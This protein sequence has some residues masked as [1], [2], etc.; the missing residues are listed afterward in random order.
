MDEAVRLQIKSD[1]ESELGHMVHDARTAHNRALAEARTDAERNAAD[2]DYKETMETVTMLAREMFQKRLHD[3]AQSQ[4]PPSRAIRTSPERFQHPSTAASTSQLTRYQLTD[5]GVQKSS[6]PETRG[7]P[8]RSPPA[9][10]SSPPT[11]KNNS[12][13]ED[14]VPGDADEKKL[15]EGPKEKQAVPN[16]ARVQQGVAGSSRPPA[17]RAPAGRFPRPAPITPA[18]PTPQQMWKPPPQSATEPSGVTRSLQRTT[19]PPAKGVAPPVKSAPS[20][21]AR[22]VKA[23][24]GAAAD[25]PRMGARAGASSG[26]SPPDVHV[27]T[28]STAPSTQRTTSGAPLVRAVPA[29]RTASSTPRAAAPISSSAGARRAPPPS[30]A[31]PPPVKASTSAS[32]SAST[33]TKP[34]PIPSMASKTTHLAPPPEKITNPSGSLSSAHSWSEVDDGV[35]GSS[36]GSA[37]I[38]YSGPKATRRRDVEKSDGLQK[39]GSSSPSSDRGGASE[40]GNSIQSQENALRSREDAMRAREVE[41]EARGAKLQAQEELSQKR[42]AAARADAQRRIDEL[43]SQVAALQAAKNELQNLEG[44]AK[45]REDAWAQKERAFNEHIADET[46]RAEQRRQ[47]DESRAKSVEEERRLRVEEDERRSSADKGELEAMRQALEEREERLKEEREQLEAERS[48]IAEERRDFAEEYSVFRARTQEFE[49]WAE[50]VRVTAETH[51]RDL[52]RREAAIQA[53]ELALAD[54][55]TDVGP[56]TGKK[57]P[58]DA[59]EAYAILRQ[60]LLAEAQDL[61]RE[62]SALDVAVGQDHDAIVALEAQLQ[63]LEMQEHAQRLEE[64]E[65][66]RQEMGGAGEAQ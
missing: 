41:L 48:V 61:E 22:G 25:H 35:S 28:A 27:S 63:G 6:P 20:A 18:R 23:G 59:G 19:N 21:P 32:A 34:V 15:E 31:R 62:A 57:G 49:S 29:Q 14:A 3:L 5:P 26:A 45:L 55:R 13:D 40:K 10:G 52:Q 46:R 43:K 47:Q 36:H 17:G 8:S 38:V 53:R 11:S 39:T 65:R 54:E 30:S 64:E 44:A 51:D 16:T 7:R 9:T 60:A 1:V 24:T 37:H 58:V 4:Q 56:A 42:D 33:P 2:R 66:Q 12:S 50:K